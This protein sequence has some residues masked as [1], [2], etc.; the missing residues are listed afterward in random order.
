MDAASEAQISKVDGPALPAAGTVIA[1]SLTPAAIAEAE[2]KINDLTLK[3]LGVE[4]AAKPPPT[5]GVSE[6]PPAV[7][8]STAGSTAR[9]SRTSDISGSTT[10]WNDADAWE[11]EDIRQMKLEAR[12]LQDKVA[13]LHEKITARSNARSV[14]KAVGAIESGPMRVPDCPDGTGSYSSG[15]Q[16]LGTVSEQSPGSA[17]QESTLQLP[18]T[19]ATETYSFNSLARV[20]E[21]GDVSA[22]STP[23]LQSMIGGLNSTLGTLVAEAG[24]RQAAAPPPA[25]PKV[26]APPRKAPP[27]CPPLQLGKFATSTVQ[28]WLELPPGKEAF[29]SNIQAQVKAKAKGRVTAKGP[30]ASNQSQRP[31]GSRPPATTTSEVPSKPEASVNASGDGLPK[32]FNRNIPPPPPKATSVV[33]PPLAGPPQP[34]PRQP[35]PSTQAHLADFPPFPSV[36]SLA[37]RIAGDENDDANTDFHMKEGEDLCS[38]ITAHNR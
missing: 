9:S 37:D 15:E 4:P 24:R 28:S 7:V 25:P 2:K 22:F 20:V 26:D 34:K 14:S 21:T 5:E 23:Y 17:P 35:E 11:K 3:S 33:S 6:Q 31:A 32:S 36:R 19:P 18:Q 12:R 10:D 16:R 38:Y 27:T 1:E 8:T 30:P 13:E 29:V